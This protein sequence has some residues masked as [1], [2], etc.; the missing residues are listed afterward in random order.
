MNT[1]DTVA[2]VEHAASGGGLFDIDPGLMIWAWVVFG[3]LFFI[4]SKFAWKPMMESVK[5]REKIL[6]DAVEH[7]KK[8]KEELENIA[9]RQEQMLK[10]TQEHSNQIIEQ[11]RKSADTAARDILEKAQKESS[12][13]LERARQQ[14]EAEK[15]QAILEIREQAVDLVLKTSEKLI[16]DVM[17]KDKHRNLVRKHLE[18][19]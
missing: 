16:F 13:L 18:E 12:V 4:L 15:Q 11:G 10:E 19:L 2:V 9:A 8:T 6:S 5:A 3:I 1:L 14:I 7:A 17:D